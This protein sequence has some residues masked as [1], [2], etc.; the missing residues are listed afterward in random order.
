MTKA[1][2]APVVLV[3]FRR[4]E[5]TAEVFEQ[6]R[7]AA[8]ARLFLVMDGPRPNNPGESTLVEKTR[9]VAENVDWP[10]QVTKIY[11]DTNM[12]LKRRVSS[13]LTEVFSHVDRAIILEDDCVPSPEFFEFCTEL[14][15]RFLDNPDVGLI[16]GAARL[17]GRAFNADSYVFSRDVRIWGWATWSRTWNGF[18]ASGDLERDWKEADVPRIARNFPTSARKRSIEG[19]L[20]AGATLDSWALPFAIHC[21]TKG[22]SNPVSGVNLV[23]NIGFGETSTHTRFE[24]YVKDVPLETMEFPLV[25]PAST[26]PHDEFDHLEAKCDRYEFWMYPLRHPLDALRR[27]IRYVRLVL[28]HKSEEK[29]GT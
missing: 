22:L 13:G 28:R 8:P 14:L 11:A 25:H 3:G 2:C 19:M 12:G 18:V 23:R 24:S 27:A 5:F 9:A 29:R 1:G 21:V 26:E 10:C 7:R 4:P 20:R 6:I 16:S 15:E 17:R